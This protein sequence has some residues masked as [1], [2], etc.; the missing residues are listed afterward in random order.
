MHTTLCDGEVKSSKVMSEFHIDYRQKNQKL[1]APARTLL[2]A[3]GGVRSQAQT[4]SADTIMVPHD[5]VVCISPCV[6]IVLFLLSEADA[7]LS[8]TVR[9]AEATSFDHAIKEQCERNCLAHLG[10]EDTFIHPCNVG[11]LAYERVGT[12]SRCARECAALAN[13]SFS[14]CMNGCD[15]YDRYQEPYVLTA[16]G[17]ASNYSNV[18]S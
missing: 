8:N 14:Y 15:F 2:P 7:E 18:E 16:H 12:N 10:N 5:C 9:G 6:A 4:P 3:P 17:V 1:A 13:N 11:C